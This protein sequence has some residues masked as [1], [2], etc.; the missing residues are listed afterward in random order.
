[1]LPFAF[2]AF[3]QC[4]QDG[5]KK[6]PTYEQARYLD[7]MEKSQNW[8]GSFQA[9]FLIFGAWVESALFRITSVLG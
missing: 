6:I 1:M 8:A 4:Q 5:L 3:H 9:W 7:H 2:Q